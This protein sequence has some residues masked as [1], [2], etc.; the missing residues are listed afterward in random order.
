MKFISFILATYICFLTVQPAVTAFYS[1]LTQQT[2]E[3]CGDNCC[4]HK[5]ADSKQKPDTDKQDPN[6]CC[7]NGICN[8]FEQCACCIGVTVGQ[9]T[10]KLIATVLIN[11]FTFPT[12][13]NITSNYS[14]DCFHP[15]EI[16]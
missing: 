10:Y 8:P 6:N 14:A 4:S 13:V 15:P 12:S 16:V 9:P 2:V 3:T 5:Q 7:P 11:E 1:T